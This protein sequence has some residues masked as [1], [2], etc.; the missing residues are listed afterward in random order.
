[1]YNGARYLS[2]AIESV[3]GQ[4]FTDFELLIGDDGSADRSRNIIEE[5]AGKDPRIVYWV[6]PK[7]L[8][9]FG[10]YNA[11][12][13][14][15]TGNFVKPFAQDDLLEPDALARMCKVLEECAGVA[16]VSTGKR[17]ISEEGEEIKR[18]IQFESDQLLSG[19]EVIIANLVNLTNWVGEPSTVM[20]RARDR[21]NG[22]DPS[23]YHYGDIEYWFR[24]L[25]EG[26]LFYLARPLCSFRRHQESSTTSNLRGLYFAL[27][28]FR[29]GDRYRHYLEELGESTEHFG[30]RT[31]EKIALYLDYLVETEELDL[32]KVL[33][34]NP[35]AHDQ[36][37]AADKTVLREAFF[38]A[39]RRITS[40]S[41]EL[42]DTRNELEH[43]QAECERLNV[44]VN[45]MANSVSWRVTAPLRSVRERINHKAT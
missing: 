20:F 2:S 38:H 45:Q 21:G 33:A 12:L 19:K 5:Y 11:C 8:G 35:G 36:F 18:V 40:L 23:Y 3:L 26:D 30:A 17:W 44:A 10:N 39:M 34:S 32:P 24:L 14:A 22:F 37:L 7:R 42:I 9:L 16:L 25:K 6:N 31:V 43:R 28:I 1:V 29:L 27:D 4:S 13:N 41:K 15:A